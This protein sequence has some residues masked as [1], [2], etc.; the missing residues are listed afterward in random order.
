[1]TTHLIGLLLGLE[2]DWPSAFEALI[3]RAAP[4]LTIKGERH[5]FTTERVLIEPFNLRDKPRH[6][7][8]IDRLAW[9][10]YM[11]RE[12]L[13]KVAMMDEVYLLNNPFTFQSMEK[14]TA[15]CAMMRLGLNIPETWLLPFK[16]GPANERWSGTSQ[17]YNKLFDLEGI[18]NRLGFPLYMKPFDGG[19]WRGVTR[20][21]NLGDLHRAYDASGQ[22]LMHLQA[23][24]A[25]FDHFLRSLSI[26]PQSRVMRYLPDK[27]QHERYATDL[28]GVSDEVADEVA[29]I[30]RLI[31]AFF[32]WEF[33][34][35]EVILKDGVLS[36]IDY[37]NA[38]PDVALTSLHVH[39]PWAM[40]ALVK[41]CVFC[42]AMGRK[43][44]IT[45]DARRYFELA[46]A[47]AEKSAKPQAL[48]VAASAK[49]V[50]EYFETD[51]FEEFC[52]AHL[53]HLDD[54]A[55]AYFTSSE[56]DDLLVR[57]VVSTFQPHE[58]D[59]YVWHY[60]QLMQRWAAEEVGANA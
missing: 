21:D 16:V 50:D 17:R 10:Y 15:Y 40:V 57:T 28:A 58:H 45:M 26:G 2:D 7:V 1:M 24:I 31:N 39:F 60:R 38:C 46:D 27:P 9:W 56:F 49:L 37:A 36:P 20:I 4:S 48:A 33:N 41:W 54:A 55:H 8:V 12:W 59:H 34:S 32:R 14:H 42:A 13:K 23:G 29:A 5:E 11:P 35:C 19:G 44:N 51:R 3:R 22:S 52:A 6:K 25:D 43:M 47:G 30:N 18:A 53:A